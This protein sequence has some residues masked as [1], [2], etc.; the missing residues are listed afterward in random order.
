MSFNYLRRYPAQLLLK[1][2]HYNRTL[3]YLNLSNNQISDQDV[4]VSASFLEKNTTLQ[5]LDLSFNMIENRG[6]I[7]LSYC[8]SQLS[9]VNFTQLNL[10]NN[11]IGDIGYKFAVE[12]MLFVLHQNYELHYAVYHQEKNKMVNN[13]TIPVK[14]TV[15]SQALAS[16][17]DE[18]NGIRRE[19]DQSE[20]N[21]PPAP[22]DASPVSPRIYRLLSIICFPIKNNDRVAFSSWSTNLASAVQFNPL[23]LS[24]KHELQLSDAFD[25]IRARICMDAIEQNPCILVKEF[26]W[27]NDV[28]NGFEYPSISRHIH[29][30][31][32]IVKPIMDAIHH[33][34]SDET[35]GLANC[36]PRVLYE[37]EYPNVVMTGPFD[38]SHHLLTLLYRLI[39]L[40]NKSVEEKLKANHLLEVKSVLLD[41]GQRLSF[42]ITPELM[43][44][45]LEKW[46]RLDAMHSRYRIGE[47][48]NPWK[49]QVSLHDEKEGGS[50]KKSSGSKRGSSGKGPSVY[51]DIE[52]ALQK[53][54]ESSSDG[55][56]LISDPVVIVKFLICNIYDYIKQYSTE[57][58]IQQ[59]YQNQHIFAQAQLLT[60]KYITLQRFANTNN[61]NS[62]STLKVASAFEIYPPDHEK[63]QM[64]PYELLV[65]MITELTFQYN[66]STG[67]SAVVSALNGVDTDQSIS[68]PGSKKVFELPTNKN[69]G[70]ATKKSSEV[71]DDEA[72]QDPIEECFVHA[73]Q[74][75]QYILLQIQNF[76]MVTCP[77]QSVKIV[78]N[79][80]PDV[81]NDLP[82]HG[83]LT[84]EMHVP[85][86]Q[87][88]FHKAFTPQK[89]YLFDA[90]LTT[91]CYDYA[92]YNHDR[93]LYQSQNDSMKLFSN[94]ANLTGTL[95]Q[96]L[97]YDD[98]ILHLTCE[99][100]ELV[101]KIVFAAKKGFH[102]NGI[103]RL[104][105]QIAD[106]NDI[107]R[108]IIRNCYFHE[109]RLI[110]FIQMN[111]LYF[112][113]L[114]CR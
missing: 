112:W 110:V 11:K 68:N 65:R 21:K 113:L 107:R 24:G 71:E 73:T 80:I 15:R 99:Q 28:V 5:S 83:I 34:C 72:L 94:V 96:I 29:S 4:V 74:F 62:K 84:L 55:E 93:I 53:E 7:A 2:L 100:A 66:N 69:F 19:N 14:K 87:S 26:K 40:L 33:V 30:N 32:S 57:M 42:N 98:N 63:I 89:H 46:H 44:F 12:R 64:N 16:V 27:Y 50:S 6:C 10:L 51:Q 25:Y 1:S 48:Y 20:I 101:L 102:L 60:A 77:Y 35:R 95:L 97:E 88:S 45:L 79:S 105:F 9:C 13:V 54:R 39:H 91:L 37:Q 111:A 114:I 92:S 75:L 59:F 81:R 104:L 108:F 109:V 103:E 31:L 56:I 49:Q 78:S 85:S 106:S 43:F 18:L 36:T 58:N 82:S 38:Q 17:Y 41:L 52:E 22:V 8:L 70:T 67:M 90:F 61:Q 23:E 76:M 86:L 3:V 47:I